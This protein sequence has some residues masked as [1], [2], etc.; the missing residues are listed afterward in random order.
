MSTLA[1]VTHVERTHRDGRTFNEAVPAMIADLDIRV[2]DEVGD[3]A[4]LAERE[5]LR[6]DAR[7][8]DLL[9]VHLSLLEGMATSKMEGIAAHTW[10]VIANKALGTP[11]GDASAQINRADAAFSS[12]LRD[13]APTIEALNA[14]HAILLAGQDRLTPGAVRKE[15]V[16]IG[17]YHPAAA[18]FVPP[19]HESVP[20]Y[21]DD[22]GAFVDATH[23]SDVIAR[24]A[25][26][27]AQF[28]TVHPYLDGNGRTGRALTS[29]ILRR[30]GVTLSADI[31]LSLGMHRRKPEY[32]SALIAYREG[33]ADPIVDF[34]SRSAFRA[35]KLV[36]SL[37]SSL[38]HVFSRWDEEV[39]VRRDSR[40]RLI[41]DL[42][43]DRPAVTAAGLAEVIPGGASPIYPALAKLTDIG[44][45]VEHNVLV[46]HKVGRGSKVWI[47]GEVAG[48][49]TAAMS[50]PM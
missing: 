33:D 9:N 28:E 41:L 48:A 38:F 27:H 40:A 10:D 29:A 22:L 42:L 35:V 15:R 26:A 30:S 20:E 3:R 39:K 43:S 45:L 24:A 17:G 37:V 13:D 18:S 34:Y 12:L 2:S 32:I 8:G 21:L 25:I 5:L 19:A 50:A 36:G 6:A 11:G 44:V 46:D 23:G 49:I 47:A 16:W 4:R 7:Y 31:P 1:P 14:S